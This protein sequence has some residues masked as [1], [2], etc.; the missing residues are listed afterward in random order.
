MSTV[1]LGG[2]GI[3]RPAS[4]GVASA[5]DSVVEQ[6][7]MAVCSGAIRPGTIM[8]V[9]DIERVVLAS[10]SVVRE[11]VRALSALGL[12]R[13]KRRVGIEVLG[14]NEWNVFDRRVIR[15]SLASPARAEIVRSLV[16]MRMALEPEAARLAAVDA[17]AESAGQ[18]L[19]VAGQLWSTAVEGDTEGFLRCDAEFHRVILQA[20]GNVLFARMAGLIQE[21]L[22]EQTVEQ[23]KTSPID[24]GDVQLHLD[25]A[26]HIQ[27]RE[28]Q[29]ASE[30]ARDIISHAVSELYGYDARVSRV[31]TRES[32]MRGLNPPASS[33]DLRR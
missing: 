17:S 1:D 32:G 8:L 2:L 28:S 24:L 20:S 29:Q 19:G 5:F 21:A 6:V 4:A 26:N 10:R 15:W 13:S 9:E 16:E 31:S 25:L 7:G 11:A 23:L 27:R 18:I 30:R 12:L 22:R 14:F 3:F 33:S